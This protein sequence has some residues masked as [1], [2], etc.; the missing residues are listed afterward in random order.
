MR[1]W[2]GL[3]VCYLRLSLLTSALLLIGCSESQEASVDSHAP[4]PSLP[5]DPMAVQLDDSHLI[6]GR[7]IWVATCGQCHIRGL[8]G[9]PIIG[10]VAVWAPRIAQGKAVLYEHAINGFTGPLLNEMP[11]KGG[12]D[13]LTDEQ[14]KLAVDFVVHASQSFKQQQIKLY[15]K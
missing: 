6:A 12:F 13:D 10:D 5:F 14:V 8:G 2:F 3:G 11:P 1:N 9:A 4:K 7:E 15:N